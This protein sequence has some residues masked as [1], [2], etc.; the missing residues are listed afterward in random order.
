MNYERQLTSD[1]N[2]NFNYLRFRTYTLSGAY[3]KV[4]EKVQNLSW[5]SIRYNNPTDNLIQSDY[6]ELR[7]FD[8]PVNNP[9]NNFQYA[10]LINH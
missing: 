10:T 6:E 4:L 1:H 9:G 7:G 5:E 2:F 8:G 3:R